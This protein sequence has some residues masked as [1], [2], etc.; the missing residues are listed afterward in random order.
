VCN[1]KKTEEV[2]TMASKIF[3]MYLDSE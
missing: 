1:K 3:R 2:M